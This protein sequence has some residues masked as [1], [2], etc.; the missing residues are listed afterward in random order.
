MK[1]DVT[2]GS[3]EYE[4]I[5]TSEADF[6]FNN[7]SDLTLVNGTLSLDIWGAEFFTSSLGTKIKEALKHRAFTFVDTDVY[8][9]GKTTFLFRDVRKI[10]KSNGEILLETDIKGE[11]EATYIIGGVLANTNVFDEIT[12]EADEMFEMVF[13]TDDFISVE[14]YCR[15]PKEYSYHK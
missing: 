6:M 12:I 15:K 2:V 4:G 14:E 8:I 1:I 11:A 9:N 7:W 13:D 5:G 3:N 10:S